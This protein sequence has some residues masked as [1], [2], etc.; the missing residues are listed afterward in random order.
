MR[1]EDC[2]TIHRTPRAQ[3]HSAAAFARE[4][5]NVGLSR[6]TG[7]FPMIDVRGALAA[8]ADPFNKAAPIAARCMARHCPGVPH[9]CSVHRPLRDT[10]GSRPNFCPRNLLNICP[11]IDGRNHSW[12]DFGHISGVSTFSWRGIWLA[13]VAACLV[14]ASPW[15]PLDF[16]WNAGWVHFVGTL[17]EGSCLG[18]RSIH[19]CDT[20]LT[21]CVSSSWGHDYGGFYLEVA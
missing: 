17:T 21:D 11:T 12:V 15:Y 3:E 20:C 9:H 8:P 1:A 13:G 10:L 14:G 18:F 16:L 5:S 2:F 7:N 6:P 19:S 4:R